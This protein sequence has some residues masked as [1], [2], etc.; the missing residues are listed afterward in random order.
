MLNKELL[1]RQAAVELPAREMLTGWSKRSN[2]ARIRQDAFAGCGNEATLALV[3]AN[4]CQN[5]AVNVAE[6]NQSN[7]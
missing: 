1:E 5:T 7:G 4:V 2:R 3:Q 6:V